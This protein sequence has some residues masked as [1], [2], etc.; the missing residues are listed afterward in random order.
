VEWLPAKQWSLL[1]ERYLEQDTHFL[2]AAVRW[3]GGENWS[4]DFSRAQRLAGPGPSAWTVGYTRVFG[5]K[6]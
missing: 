4:V 2:R 1:A 3:L 5:V 6:D